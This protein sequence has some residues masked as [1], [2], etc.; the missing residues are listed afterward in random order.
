MNNVSSL[1][2]VAAGA[3]VAAA[4]VVIFVLCAIV[5]VIAP[6]V[7]AT[8]AWISLFT[9]APIGSAGAWISGILSSAVGGFVAGW[10]FAFVYNRASK[11]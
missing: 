11:A 7:Q 9:S 3:G 10:V 6:N 1:S 4:L 2:A 5:Q 8:H